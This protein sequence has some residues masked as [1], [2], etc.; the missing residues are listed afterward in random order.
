MAFGSS[1][2]KPFNPSVISATSPIVILPASYVLL[3]KAEAVELGWIS[4]NAKDLYESGVTAS[5]EQWNL[6]TASDYL[7]GSAEFNNGAGGGS[8]IGF[9]SEFPSIVGADANTTSSLERIRLQRYL[10]SFGD[11]IQAW[12]EWRRTGIPR[13]KPTAF[14]VNTPKEIPRRLTYGTTEYAANPANVAAAAARLSGGDVM[15]SRMWWDRP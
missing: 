11:G 6:S 10:A 13:L 12:A 14:G 9:I 5:F 1:Y 7:A 4:G 8:D 15:N 2:A 3:A